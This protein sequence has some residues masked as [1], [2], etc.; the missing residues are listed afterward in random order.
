MHTCK[1]VGVGICLS[2]RGSACMP[3]RMLHVPCVPMSTGAW[4]SQ[5]SGE[6]FRAT[7]E[8]AD[9]NYTRVLYKGN[10]L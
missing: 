3:M 10:K 6:D 7:M 1:H 5:T 2:G 9:R 4:G 8:G